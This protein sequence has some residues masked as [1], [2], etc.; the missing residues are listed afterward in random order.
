[1]PRIRLKPE[2]IYEFNYRIILKPR[3]MNYG[4]HMGND[5]LV[6][7][8]G[9]AR[10]NLFKDLGCSEGDLGDGRTAI[11]M[12]DLAVNYKSEGFMFDELLVESHLG[13]ITRTGMRVFHRITK[14]EIL[15][16][17]AETGL[18]AFDYQQH[19]IAE[20]PQTF[21]ESLKKQIETDE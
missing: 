7:L 21:I 6:T 16:A 13:D 19:R 2:P 12:A 10:A 1:M 14:G 15:V 3:D 8:I 20:I 18:L 9:E 11:I 5:T 17:L 4:G